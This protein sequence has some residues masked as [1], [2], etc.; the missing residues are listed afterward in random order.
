MGGAARNNFLGLFFSVSEIPFSD[1][2]IPFSKSF[3]AFYITL[4]ITRPVFLDFFSSLQKAPPETERS[5]GA[6]QLV[7]VGVSSLMGCG[8]ANLHNCALLFLIPRRTAPK[9]PLQGSGGG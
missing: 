4:E 3:S 9:R 8:R 6:E 5:S 7:E 1:S 2:E